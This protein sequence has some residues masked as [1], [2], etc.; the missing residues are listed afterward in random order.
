MWFCFALKSSNKAVPA[1]C[2]SGYFFVA[3]Y[4]SDKALPFSG[5]VGRGNRYALAIGYSHYYVLWKRTVVLCS[6]QPSYDHKYKR[7][8]CS[9]LSWRSPFRARL[10]VAITVGFIVPRSGVPTLN[11]PNHLAV[12]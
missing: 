5:R 10:S 12:Q 2:R 9:P 7:L 1:F 11:T 8:R 6:K 3:S 4:F